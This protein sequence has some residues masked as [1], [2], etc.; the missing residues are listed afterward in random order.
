[1]IIM[2]KLFLTFIF[3]LLSFPAQAQEA[4]VVDLS[5]HIID[6]KVK[7]RDILEY[8]LTF[9]NNS[10]RKQVLYPILNDLSELAGRQENVS[11]GKLDKAT[12]L[13]RWMKIKRGALELL[14]GEIKTLNLEIN[15]N[16]QAI[17]G[18]YHASIV[19]SPGTNI[20]IAKENALKK[21][22]AQ[23]LVNI[24]VEDV[25]VE[26]A[27]LTK[28]RAD[29]NVF[30]KFPVNFSFNI[31]NLGNRD[32]IPQGSIFIYNRRDAEVAELKINEDLKII[33]EGEN[34]DYYISW[35]PDKAL[36]KFKAKIE[37]EYGN[38]GL[39]DLSDTAYFWVLPLY[40]LITFFGILFFVAVFLTIFLF[41]KTYKH[42]QVL[43]HAI[44]EEERSDGVL[45]L[46][47]RDN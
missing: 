36:G 31:S 44:E 46:K 5:P 45:D 7:I 35:T 23:L 12:S 16:E 17:P 25:I 11:P 27:Q 33:K 13:V 18:K 43:G 42:E 29:K 47:N 38:I 8:E 28:Y 26:K 14:P 34:E 3:L 9:T 30:I 4:S 20:T 39:R 19:F 40:F 6:E 32:I 41:K 2:K 21:D 10:E 24:S 15:I 22:S 37:M 1:M